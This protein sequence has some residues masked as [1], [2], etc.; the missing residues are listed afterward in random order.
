MACFESRGLSTDSGRFFLIANAASF[1]GETRKD[2]AGKAGTLNRT[3]IRFGAKKS[4][5][6]GR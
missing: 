2:F 1:S 6:L 5:T 3:S 4:G